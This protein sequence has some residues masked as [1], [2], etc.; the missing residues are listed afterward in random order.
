MIRDS[1]SS[2]TSRARDGPRPDRVSPFAQPCSRHGD[3]FQADATVVARHLP[4]EQEIE[5]RIAQCRRA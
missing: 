2:L 5:T 1:L 4:V 3:L